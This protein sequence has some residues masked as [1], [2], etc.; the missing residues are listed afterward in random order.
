MKVK[1]LVSF[2]CAECSAYVGE[3]I[4]LKNDL[5]KELLKCGYVEKITTKKKVAKN[6]DQRI[7][8]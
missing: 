1:A 8:K 2:A 7:N 6:E 4:D 5:V 3:V